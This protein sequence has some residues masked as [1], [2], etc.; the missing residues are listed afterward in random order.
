MNASELKKLLD[1]ISTKGNLCLTMIVGQGQD[2]T[3]LIEDIKK[4][5][6]AAFVRQTSMGVEVVV[7]DKLP[8]LKS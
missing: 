7:T 8:S 3:P 2:A 4:T 6:Y 5:G 1:E